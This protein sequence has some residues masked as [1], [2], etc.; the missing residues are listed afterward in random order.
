MGHFSETQL[1][2]SSVRNIVDLA[3][4]IDGYGSG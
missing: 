1:D 4:H 3:D 2:A